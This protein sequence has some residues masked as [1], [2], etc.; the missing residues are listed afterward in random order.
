MAFFS[1]IQEGINTE[2]GCNASSSTTYNTYLFLRNN[3]YSDVKYLDYSESAVVDCLMNKHLCLMRGGD[4]M[5]KGGHIWVVWALRH[6]KTG[7]NY[8]AFDW[9]WN[10]VANGYFLAGIVDPQQRK[11]NDYDA[12]PG[13][14]PDYNFALDMKIITDIYR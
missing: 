7:T 11:W 14:A 3:G 10:G 12:A 4:T 6:A 1:F 9:G 5:G 8:F 2:W 13:T